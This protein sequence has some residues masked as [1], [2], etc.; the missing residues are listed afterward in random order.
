MIE[1]LFATDLAYLQDLYNRDQPLDEAAA[2]PAL[3]QA[4]CQRRRVRTEE[5]AA[6]GSRRLPPRPTERGGGL[7]RL[8]L[9]L[10]ARRDHGARARDRR[11]WVRAD[12]G[13]QPARERGLMRC[14]ARSTTRALADRRVAALAAAARHRAFAGARSQRRVAA[15]ALHASGRADAAPRALRDRVARPWSRCTA[16]RAAAPQLR[17]HRAAAVVDGSR[18]AASRMRTRCSHA[19][20]SARVRRYARR[21]ERASTTVRA[22]GDRASHGAPSSATRSSG[23]RRFRALAVTRLSRAPPPPASRDR[24]RGAPAAAI[25]VPRA[26]ATRRERRAPSRRAPAP[27]PPHELVARDRPRAPRSSTAAC[28]S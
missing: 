1:G 16:H 20:S 22:S 19:S 5:R 28:S 7:H 4:R 23:T 17:S 27:L 12:L 26:A 11:R 9:P 14:A 8:P 10:A 21:I 15:P 25:D 18:R 3:R 2:L 13:A 6:W 24:C